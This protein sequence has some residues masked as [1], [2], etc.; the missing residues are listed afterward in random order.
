MSG[1]MVQAK[2]HSQIEQAAKYLEAH[3]KYKIRLVHVGGIQD[4]QDMKASR[5]LGDRVLL[6]E[7]YTGL[8]HA[9]ATKPTADVYGETAK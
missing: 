9:V 1:P 4:N 6:R 3:P 2:A 5:A 7:W 8:M